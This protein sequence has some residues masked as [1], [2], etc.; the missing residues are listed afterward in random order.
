MD[1]TAQQPR[2]AL[3]VSIRKAAQMTGATPKAIRSRVDRK[4]LR[5]VMHDGERKIP[6]SEL[7]RAGLLNP[8]GS[9]AGQAKQG[10]EGQGQ[11]QGSPEVVFNLSELIDQLADARAEA[12]IKGLIAQQAETAA[13]G[14]REARAALELELHEAR[15]RVQ[16]LEAE[17]HRPRWFK[18]RRR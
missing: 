17:I 9:P 5:Y 16:A 2:E 12:R 18:L 4:S 10:S 7:H 13:E 14:E 15:A 11:Q 6:V 3:A 1:A 8:D